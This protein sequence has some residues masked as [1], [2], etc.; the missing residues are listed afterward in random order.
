MKTISLLYQG[1][2]Y[3]KEFS[4]HLEEQGYS[5]YSIYA[6]TAGITIVIGIVL[7]LM[8]VFITDYIWPPGGKIKLAQKT[9]DEV[10]REMPLGA[11]ANNEEPCGGCNANKNK[12]DKK[13]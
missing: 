12:S 5:S 1:S 11:T 13:N 6:L 3:V 4:D 9:P 8:L 10:D 7:G 2:V